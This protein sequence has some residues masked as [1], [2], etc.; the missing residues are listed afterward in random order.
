MVHPN[1]PAGSSRDAGA[2]WGRG[3]GSRAVCGSVHGLSGR[4]HPA[5]G[6]QAR[7][8]GAAQ[9]LAHHRVPVGSTVRNTSMQA[10]A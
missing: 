8:W 9:P 7:S 3:R 2:D 10:R 1:Q 4:L 5:V 6:A